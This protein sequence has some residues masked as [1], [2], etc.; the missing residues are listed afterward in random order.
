MINCGCAKFSTFWIPWS[1]WY[2]LAGSGQE[3]WLRKEVAWESERDFALL[4]FSINLIIP[5]QYSV[6]PPFKISI[7]HSLTNCWSSEKVFAE[8]ESISIVGEPEIWGELVQ[9]EKEEVCW[10]GFVLLA[11]VISSFEILSFSI[12]EKFSI[13]KQGK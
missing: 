7:S 13:L 1:C 12:E 4:W 2:M 8:S 3:N 9:E 10:W 6:S 11:V 5:L